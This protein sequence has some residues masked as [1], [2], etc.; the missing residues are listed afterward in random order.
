MEILTSGC[1]NRSPLLLP[2][3]WPCAGDAVDQLLPW[4]KW[5]LGHSDYDRGVYAGPEHGYCNRAAG[6]RRGTRCV[7]NI[8]H[9]SS[10][11]RRASWQVAGDRE[12]DTSVKWCRLYP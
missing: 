4:M 7:A 9:T 6:K 12:R 10:P 2:L 8:R 1:A 5:D 3:A 11:Q